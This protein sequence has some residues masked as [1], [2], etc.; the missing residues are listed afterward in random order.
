MTLIG[1]CI[2]KSYCLY[3]N[4]NNLLAG[5]FVIYKIRV[6][7]NQKYYWL[8]LKKDVEIYVRGCN[9][10]L[11]SKAVRHKPDGDLQALQVLTHQWKDLS[12]D[13][14]TRLLVSTH[15][16]G[17]SYDSI[18]VIVDR[19]TKIIYYEPVKV[20]IDALGLAGIIFNMVVSHHGLSNSIVSN[21]SSL[22]IFK[23]WSSL[24]YLFGRTAL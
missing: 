12:I 5:H 7:I 22:F 24:Y 3:L 14:V 13:F 18:L 2:T 1:W 11:A 8:I 23:F 17:K 16:K 6:L 15:W 21:R 9:I 4:Y 10:Y 19:L 20:N